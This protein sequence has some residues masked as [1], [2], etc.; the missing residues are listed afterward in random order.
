MG[1][2]YVPGRPSTED[3]D[4]IYCMYVCTYPDDLCV[5]LFQVLLLYLF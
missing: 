5:V 3:G 2:T 4:L 1:A